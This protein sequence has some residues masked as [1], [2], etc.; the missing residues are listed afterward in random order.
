MSQIVLQIER[1]FSRVRN[2]PVFSYFFGDT[3]K[4]A[5]ADSCFVSLI[6]DEKEIQLRQPTGWGE[7]L[8]PRDLFSFLEKYRTE[9]GSARPDQNVGEGL[10]SFLFSG[11][12]AAT[13]AQIAAQDASDHS[14]TEIL[15]RGDSTSLPLIVN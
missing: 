5:L 13:I 2:T 7:S 11:P 10:H 15:I 9:P 14:R 6:V 3:L 8:S 4:K 12:F 1:D